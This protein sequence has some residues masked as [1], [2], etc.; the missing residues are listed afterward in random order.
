MVDRPD[1]L[2]TRVVTRGFVAGRWSRASS[3]TCER[4]SIIDHGSAPAERRSV[5]GARMLAEGATWN[6]IARHGVG[7]AGNGAGSID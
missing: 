6:P 4:D 5:H 2:V 7:A 3:L 1:F